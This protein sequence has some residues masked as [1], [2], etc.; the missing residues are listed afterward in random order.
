MKKGR[1]QKKNKNIILNWKIGGEAGFGIKVTGQMFS[2][3]LTRAGYFTY[4]YSEYPSLI[5]GGHNTYQVAAGADPVRSAYA[6][7]DFLI[8]L[9]QDAWREQQ[10]E[11]VPGAAVVYD[12]SYVKIPERVAKAKKLKLY[13]APLEEIAREYGDPIMR[14]VVALGMTVQLFGLDFHLLQGVLETAFGKKGKD[15]ITLNMQLAQAGAAVIGKRRFRHLPPAKEKKRSLMNI[16]GNTALAY[17]AIRGGL[18][19]YAGYPMTPSSSILST[20]AKYARE[21]GMVVKHAEDEISVINMAIGAGFA[22]ARSMI[23]TSGGGFA[24]MSEALGL[25]G[26]TE[27]G[28]VMVDV[29][30]PGP[31]TGLPTWTGQG[32]LRFVL[33]TAQDDVP[34]IVLTPGDPEEC[35]FMA[36]E[37]LNLAEEY[38]T[39]VIIVSDKLLA[40]SLVSMPLFDEK[41]VKIR[42]GKLMKQSQLKAGAAFARYKESADGISPRSLP[43][44]K[45]G[46]FIANSDEHDPQGIVD[47]TAETRNIQHE[48]RLRKLAT[49]AKKMPEQRLY[50]PKNAAV[51]FIGWGSTKGAMLDAL[52]IINSGKKPRGAGSSSGGKA[53]FLH[54]THAFPFPIKSVMRQLK[55]AKRI[56]SIEGNATGQFAGLLRE[57]TGITTDEQLLKYDGRPFY[58]HEIVTFFESHAKKN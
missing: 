54:I 34:R 30:R 19:F 40:A 12:A 3:M 36:A 44:M 48:K 33:H 24:L 47:E 7:V 8:C 53:N 37:A 35:F 49:Y 22:G 6:D 4:D 31:A 1:T 28:V 51:T 38:Q 42:R 50:G 2:R 20:V 10:D 25:A 27:V 32:D 15:V 11:L 21:Y 58:P 39:P 5:R 26:M 23:A 46:M 57:H 41:K 14:N 43:G 13:P 45:H 55:N 29:Q 16:D 52:D 18:Q 56:V 17:G 9:N